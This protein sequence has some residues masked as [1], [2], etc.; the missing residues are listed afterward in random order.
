MQTFF[1]ITGY[2][3]NFFKNS[4]DFLKNNIRSLA[5]PAVFF[6]LLN[7]CVLASL[8]SASVEDAIYQLLHGI[9]FW[10]LWTLL[11]CKTIYFFLNKYVKNVL[12]IASIQFVL[13][14]LGYASNLS[15]FQ[16]FTYHQLISCLCV[17]V[18]FGVECK[19]HKEKYNM[20]LKFGWLYI[21]VIIFVSLYNVPYSII[22]GTVNV[23]SYKEVPVYLI[24]GLLGTFFILWLAD[25]LKSVKLFRIA[26]QHSLCIYGFHF[27]FL[28]IYTSVI[29]DHILGA[30]EISLYMKIAV[31]IMVCIATYLSSL[32]M[33]KKLNEFSWF[34]F[35]I[36]KK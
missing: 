16:D 1:F 5:I 7:R 33:S 21:P 18:F 8:F 17:F 4:S 35:L 19:I 14:I 20:L 26:G 6:T 11:M 32:Y 3:T 28:C 22:S 13:L 2:C 29:F 31:Y 27:V 23:G 10:F 15:G 24:L 12:V 9:G 36:G 25:L 30:N 34:K